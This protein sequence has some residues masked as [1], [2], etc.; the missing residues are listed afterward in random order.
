MFPPKVVTHVKYKP[1]LPVGGLG[2]FD[3]VKVLKSLKKEVFRDIQHRIM[4]EPFS[5]AA[6]K[7]LLE[8]FKLI[9]G[10]NRLTIEAINP[11]FQP[12]LEGQR[13]GQMRW[14]TKARAPI[15][16]VLDSGE[17]IFRSATPRSMQNGSWYH[18]GRKPT[19]VI[20]KATEAARE[21]IKRRLK[22]QL[23]SELRSMIGRMR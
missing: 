23:K 14:L 18:P 7:A 15:P 21:T 1:L 13:P 2:K 20:E 12:L 17:V 5:P 4:Q 6:K 9:I 11:A 8:G 22:K 16:I 19:K 10:E 3:S